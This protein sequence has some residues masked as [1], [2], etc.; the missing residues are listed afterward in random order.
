M[1]AR[2]KDVMSSRHESVLKRLEKHQG[3]EGEY[4]R[5][6]GLNRKPPSQYQERQEIQPADNALIDES[7][8]PCSAGGASESTDDM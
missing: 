2:S 6:E 1:A 8:T 3:R 4:V 7:A 5:S